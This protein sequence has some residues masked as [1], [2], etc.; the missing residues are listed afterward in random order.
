MKLLAATAITLSLF[1]SASS[2]TSGQTNQAGAASG[3]S[4]ATNA[5]VQDAR[6]IKITRSGSQ[7]SQ[8]APGENFTGQVSVEPLFQANAP[9]RAAGAR[10]TY[11]HA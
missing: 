5:S 10:V 3:T 4:A 8:Q 6:T 11:A 2:Q 7:P 1:A 9:A